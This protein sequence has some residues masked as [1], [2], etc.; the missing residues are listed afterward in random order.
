MSVTLESLKK[1]FYKNENDF[2]ICNCTDYYNEN[3][4]NNAINLAF[5]DFTS[6]TLTKT[7]QNAQVDGDKRKTALS[8]LANKFYGYFNNDEVK[9]KEEFEKWHQDS[10]NEFIISY[11]A[12][13]SGY[14]PIGYG[15]AQKIVNMTFK[16]L[17]CYADA[18]NYI[19]KEYFKYCHMPL[20][21]FTLAWY[22]RTM[23]K[24]FSGSWSN[25]KED[26]YYPIQDKIHKYLL[27][28]PKF[29]FGSDKINLPPNSLEAEFFVWQNERNNGSF[30]DI[31]NAIYKFDKN[32][33]DDMDGDLINS[34]KIGKKKA[35]ISQYSDTII[36]KLEKLM[37]KLDELSRT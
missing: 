24:Q 9:N 10:C 35:E 18:V 6:R 25:M 19:N 13:L 33:I 34:I 29:K 23:D 11:N 21:S 12:A 16:Y 27:D 37:D 31:I 15:K 17:Y 36:P 7:S 32:I 20:D 30:K 26:E 28:E 3:G 22:K 4:G 5:K 14:Q 1:Y 8:E 2:R